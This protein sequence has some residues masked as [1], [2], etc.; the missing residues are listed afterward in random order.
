MYPFVRLAFVGLVGLFRFLPIWAQLDS[1][2]YFPPIYQG[3]GTANQGALYISTPSVSPVSF[4]ITTGTGSAVASGTVSNSQYFRYQM[5]GV[6]ST[7]LIPSGNLNAPLSNKGFVVRASGP[8]YANL[9]YEAVNNNQSFSITGKGRKAFG[10]RFRIAHSLAD[11]VS[12]SNNEVCIMA[13]ENNTSIT[14][15]LSGTGMTL[16]GPGAP[17]T[18]SPF[19]FLLNK[20]ESYVFATNNA[21]NGANRNNM[22]GHLITSNRPIVTV[23]G[24]YLGS[25]FSGN[26][27]I[28][29]DQPVSEDLLG[30]QFAFLQGLGSNDKE[31]VLIVA[32]QNGTDVFVNGSGVPFAS[33]NAG[34]FVRI[35][36]TFY[37]SDSVMFVQ[38]SQPVYAWQVIFGTNSW[39]NWGL[40]FVPPVS[41]LNERF[42][43]FIPAIDSVGTQRFT[44]NLNIITYAGSSMLINGAVPAVAP[45]PIPGSTLESYRIHGLSGSFSIYSNSIAVVGFYGRN[46]P[47]SYAGYFSGFDS[48]PEIFASILDTVCPD[49]LFVEDR[50]DSYQWLYNSST[51]VGAVDTFVGL[52]GLVGA[53][54]VIV[55]KGTCT[56]TSGAYIIACVLPL[57]N[58][59]FGVSCRPDGRLE[60][61]WKP[62]D[63]DSDRGYELQGSADGQVWR[64]LQFLAASPDQAS[65][66]W[67][68]PVDFGGLSWLRLRVLSRDGRDYFSDAEAIPCAASPPMLSAF[69]NPGSGP[70]QVHSRELGDRLRL[71]WYALDGRLFL[72]GEAV[73]ANGFTDSHWVLPPGTYWL[74]ATGSGGRQ[75]LRVV[76]W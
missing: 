68:A 53:F 36:G 13:T 10:Q 34:Q 33:L 17:S 19:S 70:I 7:I 41:C 31:N 55:T 25:F 67:R 57:A 35:P 54:N 58:S 18:A 9:R 76:V 24:N 38:T 46:G 30:T 22:V 2:H 42:V 3:N 14:V 43:D 40:N 45:R 23:M 60:A 50:F 39:A 69:P 51:L 73:G 37:N 4:T 65:Y 20:G 74:V 8:V 75:G 59:D 32:N 26:H 12:S 16:V 11:S 27:D 62:M 28:G 29:L 44:G 15:D 56:D 63:A 47:S 21:T 48:V 71:D 61:S 6:N 66:R 49:T 1:I 5:S 52:N 64:P 72:S